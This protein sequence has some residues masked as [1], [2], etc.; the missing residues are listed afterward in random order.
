MAALAALAEPARGSTDA[1]P[2]HPTAIVCSYK[3]A[4]FQVTS[5]DHTSGVIDVKGKPVRLGDGISCN[6]VRA[7]AFL[8]GMVT[9]SDVKAVSNTAPRRIVS[10]YGE[11]ESS[12]QFAVDSEYTATV[13]PTRSYPDCFFV[14]IDFD[15]AFVS[16]ASEDPSVTFAFQEIGPLTANVK[17]TVHTAFPYVSLKGRSMY[18]LALFFSHGTEIKSNRADD[19]A[20]FFR[21][22]DMIQHQKLLNLYLRKNTRSSLAMRPYLRFAPIFGDDVDP[23]TIPA[24][25]KVTSLVSTE[26]TVT[27]VSVSPAVPAPV[28][29]GV[30]RALMGWLYLPRLENGLAQP[31]ESTIELAFP[32][33]VSKAPRPGGQ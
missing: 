1:P 26:G 14:V 23:A 29:I 32:K 12:A 25:L 31:A 19:E 33:P 2:I 9:V 8:P 6:A 11:S 13:V 24:S 30:R 16:G 4:S 21:R 7:N 17:T 5:A 28:L 15:G 18:I 10:T 27:D 3:G 22:V 20:A